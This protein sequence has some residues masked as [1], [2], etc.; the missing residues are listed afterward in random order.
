MTVSFA[1]D[2]YT[3]A[4]GGGPVT[5]TVSLDKDPERA[6]TIPLTATPGDGATADDYS[7]SA[8][9]V[10]FA[11]GGT[12][13]RTF[14]VTAVDDDIDDDGETVLLEFG[15][16]PGRVTGE[17]PESATV[18]ITDDDTRGVTV[19]ETVLTI[20]EGDSDTYTVVLGSAPTAPVTVT[21]A[22][23]AGTHLTVSPQRGRR[24]EHGDGVAERP[25]ER[26]GDGD[27]VG[28]GGVLRRCRAT[29][30][31]AVRRRRSRRVRR[32]ARAR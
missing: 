9:E 11:A 5:V 31:R 22:G 30:R 23:W 1:A 28:R 6:V 15:T 7:V 24:E 19:S 4:E 2:A 18:T 3:A 10:E 14:T 26:G 25:V 17:A 29:S 12:L 13:S 21:V 32:R 8:T 16:L 20:P 27:G